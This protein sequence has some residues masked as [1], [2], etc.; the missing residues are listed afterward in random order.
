MKRISVWSVNSWFFLFLIICYI[1]PDANGRLLG[2]NE[3][4]SRVIMTVLTAIGILLS[5]FLIKSTRACGRRIAV[6]ICVAYLFLL[7]SVFL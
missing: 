5:G 3:C 7:R 2:L 1:L 4:A 6:C